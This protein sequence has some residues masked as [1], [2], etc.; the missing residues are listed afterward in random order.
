M[1]LPSFLPY[2][3]FLNLITTLL[4]VSGRTRIVHI[5]VYSIVLLPLLLKMTTLTRSYPLLSCFFDLDC[6]GNI[7]SFLVFLAPV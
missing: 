2:Q 5:Y 4:S 6:A 7:I 1:Q 3:R